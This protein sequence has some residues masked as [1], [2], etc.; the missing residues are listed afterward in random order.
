MISLC[1]VA[2]RSTLADVACTDTA[3]PGLTARETR[4]AVV[5][6]VKAHS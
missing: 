2:R 5:A 6:V 4:R 3:R 1:E